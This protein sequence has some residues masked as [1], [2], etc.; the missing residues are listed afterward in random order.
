MIV[1][2]VQPGNDQLIAAG[3]V[4]DYMRMPTTEDHDFLKSALLL[5]I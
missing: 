3:V 4:E 5:L 1:A 2:Q